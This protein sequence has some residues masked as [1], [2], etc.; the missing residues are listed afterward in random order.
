MA[1]NNPAPS[2]SSSLIRSAIPLVMPTQESVPEHSPPRLH[3]SELRG[4]A[5]IPQTVPSS[6]TGITALIR[7]ASA[8]HTAIV[9]AL[10]HAG[11]NV[12]QTDNFGQTALIFA[13][14]NGRTSAV[15][16]L[17]Q[18]R[19]NVKHKSNSGRTALSAARA[20]KHQEVVRLLT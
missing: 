7:S 18:A 15:R 17:L 1:I 19:A 2:T 10:L 13:A 12:D 6:G 3:S 20:G 16:A 11:A 8:G 5:Q 9:Q 4:P 14:E